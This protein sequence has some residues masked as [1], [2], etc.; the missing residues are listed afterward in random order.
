[1]VRL[2]GLRREQSLQRLVQGAEVDHPEPHARVSGCRVH[3]DER[4]AL[5]A[6]EDAWV[7]K[8]GD[9][10]E[11]GPGALAFFGGRGW[12]GDDFWWGCA[13]ETACCAEDSEIVGCA[14]FFSGAAALGTVAGGAGVCLAEEA[15]LVEAFGYHAADEEVLVWR[16]GGEGDDCGVEFLLGDGITWGCELR[17]VLD[18]VG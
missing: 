12:D 11:G 18:D 9:V 10:G 16:P 14:F 17:D 5:P 2:P 4:F 6:P 15:F 1:M 3:H 13:A 8:A 7:V